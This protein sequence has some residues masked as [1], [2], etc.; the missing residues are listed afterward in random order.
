VKNRIKLV[1]I[2]KNVLLLTC[3][4]FII[5]AGNCQGVIDH[6]EDDSEHCEVVI[7]GPASTVYTDGDNIQ[8]SA[9]LESWNELNEK[10]DKDYG[11]YPNNDEP[12]LYGVQW[13][14]DIDGVILTQ[15]YNPR[16][17]ADHSF[18]ISSLTPGKHTIRCNALDS[19][20]DPMCYDEIMIEIDEAPETTKQIE[21]LTFDFVLDEAETKRTFSTGAESFY[22]RISHDLSSVCGTSSI[23]E[24]VYTTLFDKGD[25]NSL[26]GQ[27]TVTF[28]D[29][30]MRVNVHAEWSR[31]LVDCITNYIVDYEG[32]PFN[33]HPGSASDLYRESGSSVSKINISQYET[34][35]TPINR[36]HS[37]KELLNTNCGND[38]EIS[39]YVYYKD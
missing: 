32:I 28:L 39:V 34:I 35:C 5:T 12:E 20:S 17:K 29:D 15:E 2:L 8:F 38:A 4:Y 19:S 11:I 30:P 3:I 27:M 25:C 10:E 14:S 9:H 26:S 31:L 33:G 36:P 7:N 23:F 1:A 24:N 6:L 18:S 22:K 13:T 16:T 21:Y 37:T